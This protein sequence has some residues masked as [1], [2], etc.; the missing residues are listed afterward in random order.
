MF[1]IGAVHKIRHQSGGGERVTRFFETFG[2]QID[3]QEIKSYTDWGRLTK[4][5]IEL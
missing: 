5:L 2:T 3:L 1:S 4:T